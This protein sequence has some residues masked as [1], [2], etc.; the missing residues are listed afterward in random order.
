[1]SPTSVSSDVPAALL[2]ERA[3]EQR[4][5]LHNTVGE[6]RDQVEGTV[7]EKL[8]LRRYAGDYAWQAAGVAALF[9]LL[10]GYGTA[11]VLKKIVS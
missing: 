7:R 4:R 6:L 9:T 10:L 11:G 1:M 2:E 5:R 8:D 3:I